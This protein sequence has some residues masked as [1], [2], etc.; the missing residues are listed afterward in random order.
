MKLEAYFKSAGC[1]N[2]L[3]Q[4]LHFYWCY[5][6]FNDITGGPEE[7]CWIHVNDKLDEKGNPPSEQLKLLIKASAPIH[8]VVDKLIEEYAEWEKYIISA[9]REHVKFSD[10]LA[11]SS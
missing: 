7:K 4:S 9:Y 5:P 3:V 6:S 1:H 8:L 2:Y 11:Q 10:A